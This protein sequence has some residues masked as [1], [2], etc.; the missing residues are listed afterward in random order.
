MKECY[1]MPFVIQMK[2]I[3]VE[4]K[5]NIFSLPN[6]IIGLKMKLMKG[7]EKSRNDTLTVFLTLLFVYICVQCACTCISE[8]WRFL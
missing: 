6:F 2:Y 7:G 1:A 4:K 5:Q 3:L 8:S